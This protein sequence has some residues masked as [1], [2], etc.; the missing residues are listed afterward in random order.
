MDVVKLKS[1]FE[2]D[3]LVEGWS[4]MIWT[5]RYSVPGDFSMTTPLIGESR[6]LIPEGSYISLLDSE[7][8]MLVETHSV[9]REEAGGVLNKI[10]GSTFPVITGERDTTGSG[11]NTSVFPSDWE[12]RKHYAPAEAVAALVWNHL[13]NNSFSMTGPTEDVNGDPI[14]YAADGRLLI[15]NLQIVMRDILPWVDPF[16]IV[17][18]DDPSPPGT[19]KW[20][21]DRGS[22]D[23][24]VFDILAQGKLGIRTMRPIKQLA[25]EIIFHNDGTLLPAADETVTSKLRLQIYQ[26]RDLSDSVV[27]RYDAGQIEKPTYLYSV[28]GYK[29]IVH[30]SSAHKSLIV[31]APGVDPNVSGLNRR[32][33]YF[34]AGDFSDLDLDGNFTDADW[35]R[36]LTQKALTELE[37]YN[38]VALFDGEIS[39]LAAVKYGADYRL[40]DR[41]TLQA[42]YDLKAEMVVSEY[43]RNQDQDGETGYPTLTFVD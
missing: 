3:V 20:V 12:L 10:S 21:I 43:I 22:L 40:G 34:D 9:E 4:S 1:N 15:P 35:D 29:N 23:R 7:E 5:E 17:D 6:A 31:A 36:I 42:E 27:F 38:K 30:V 41:V 13:V 11:V 28:K 32:V 37:N 24:P 18:V 14:V 16:P 19:R 39:P 33:L 8:V 26:G 25:R 2:P